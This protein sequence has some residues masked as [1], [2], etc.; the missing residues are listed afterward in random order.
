LIVTEALFHRRRQ[1]QRRKTMESQQHQEK[2]SQYDFA[3]LYEEWYMLQQ[4]QRQR[5]QKHA[6]S[7]KEGNVSSNDSSLAYTAAL[8]SRAGRLGNIQ[9]AILSK[10][11]T[12]NDGY[13]RALLEIMRLE[14]EEDDN[15]PPFLSSSCLNGVQALNPSQ[16]TT[17]LLEVDM[18][19]FFEEYPECMKQKEDY[20][21][22]DNDEWESSCEEEDAPKQPQRKKISVATQTSATQDSQQQQPLL[23]KKEAPGSF[24]HS[25][26]RM[27]RQLMNP[28]SSAR[29]QNFPQPAPDIQRHLTQRHPVKQTAI[30]VANP[31]QQSVE[32]SQNQF[33]TALEFASGG[34]ETA[35]SHPP[36][37]QQQQQQQL[38][39]H[40][41]GFD[42]LQG[43]EP[44]E[45]AG[46]PGAPALAIRDSLKR[47]YQDPKIGVNPA[48]L[49]STTNR[50]N[51]VAQKISGNVV[52]G[53]KGNS[54]SS[55][56][57]D[58]D[59]AEDD[60]PEELKRFGKDLV[61]KIKDEIMDNKEAIT[62]ADIA[63]LEDAKA[64]I[65][66]IVC[67]PMLRPDLFTGLRRTPNGLL[68]FGTSV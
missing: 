18:D 56:A 30:T 42:Y 54:G 14:E 12:E 22:D 44:P 26:P 68:L 23:E 57:Q 17:A 10:E 41:Y 16:A 7:N 25:Q 21:N 53:G 40:G 48:S 58:G 47:K 33:Q 65:Q 13:L 3:T 52:S 15:D 11:P 5:R 20:H 32:P 27:D 67:W 34:G 24:N 35:P 37:I 28:Y 45:E 66:E 55:A 61:N 60:L 49:S 46:S 6:K 38:H 9:A 59:S 51:D 8:A 50:K 31:V 64:T 2:P 36:Q 1:H 39:C 62:F 29:P 63:G 43:V 19:A 4:Q